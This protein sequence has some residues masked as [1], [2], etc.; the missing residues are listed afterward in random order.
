MLCPNLASLLRKSIFWRV[1]ETLFGPGQS[2]LFIR[3]GLEVERRGSWKGWAPI[4]AFP[5]PSN[6]V[7]ERTRAILKVLLNRRGGRTEGSCSVSTAP[8]SFG[9]FIKT[10]PRFLVVVTLSV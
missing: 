7:I 2:L 5:L 9:G 6:L 3:E 4:R 1:K 8:L 10:R